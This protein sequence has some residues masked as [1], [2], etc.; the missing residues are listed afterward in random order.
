[1]IGFVLCI[2]SIIGLLFYYV[3]SRIISRKNKKYVNDNVMDKV[4]EKIRLKNPIDKI[5]LIEYLNISPQ[6]TSKLLNIML[7]KDLIRIDGSKITISE[8]GKHYFDKF[9]KRR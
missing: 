1:M 4:L 5:S 8:F 7:E 3:Y 2:A 9:L 6:A